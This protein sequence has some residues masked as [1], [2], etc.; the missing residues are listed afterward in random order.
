MAL[1]TTLL[2]L[3]VTLSTATTAAASRVL[4]GTVVRAS[5]GP[6]PSAP[7]DSPGRLNLNVA[8]DNSTVFSPSNVTAAL[9]TL[10]TFYF[11]D[12]PLVSVTQSSL[13]DPCTYL[14]TSGAVGFD[15]D[16][17]TSIQYSFEVV[18]DQPIYFHCKHAGH[19]GLGMVGTINAPTDGN[20]TYE[21]YLNAAL[22]IGANEVNET[23]TAP[24]TTG[25][26]IAGV[27]TI[28]PTAAATGTPS[29][30]GTKRNLWTTGM[31]GFGCFVGLGLVMAG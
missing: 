16:L 8:P 13:E 27:T 12:S 28:F 5:E 1:A 21:A 3:S 7:P 23:N 25:Q 14:N 26:G 6:A 30:S 20:G 24:V 29:S 4:V 18:N 15:S 2:L 22:A 9:G 19:C 31:G 10:V 11:P 17:A